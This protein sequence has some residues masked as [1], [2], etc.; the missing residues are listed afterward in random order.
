MNISKKTLFFIFFLIF[1]VK[2]SFASN[3]IDRIKGR[4]YE[5]GDTISITQNFIEVK[6][7][8]TILSCSF[9]SSSIQPMNASVFHIISFDNNKIITSNFITFIDYNSIFAEGYYILSAYD[10]NLQRPMSYISILPTDP[11]LN[12]VKKLCIGLF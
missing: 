11:N 4:I 10:S 5:F 8:N 9:S 2:L 12:N 3:I 1:I 6:D 7:T